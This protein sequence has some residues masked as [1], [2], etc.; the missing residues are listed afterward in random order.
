MTFKDDGHA[1]FPISEARV[2]RHMA[3]DIVGSRRNALYYATELPVFTPMD[4]IEPVSPDKPLPDLIYVDKPFHGRGWYAK[5]AV[6]YCLHTRKLEWEDLRYGIAASGHVP[7]DLVRE[8]MDTMD[9]AWEGV[10]TNNP[11][12]RPAKRSIDS[13]VCTWGMRV[14]QVKLKS[15]LS[16]RRTDPVGRGFEQKW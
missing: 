4:D 5:G 15:S 10:L 11:N 3:L 2:A 7:G 9:A 6:D 1:E 13:M 14:E 12:H 8:A 16:F